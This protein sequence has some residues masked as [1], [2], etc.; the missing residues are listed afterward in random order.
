[1]S[2][3]HGSIFMKVN[4][5]KLLLGHFVSF[6]LNTRWTAEM[7]GMPLNAY[8]GLRYFLPPPPYEIRISKRRMKWHNVW[9]VWLICICIWTWLISLERIVGKDTDTFKVISRERGGVQSRLTVIRRVLWT[10]KSEASGK[11][12]ERSRK[13]GKNR[14]EGCVIGG[15]WAPLLCSVR[16]FFKDGP[17]SKHLFLF[18]IINKASTQGQDFYIVKD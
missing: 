1:M 14:G 17:L 6:G 8:V 7:S 11:D 4:W 12:K 16:L 13:C 2:G 15:K 9:S 10:W 5:D 18:Q 3:H